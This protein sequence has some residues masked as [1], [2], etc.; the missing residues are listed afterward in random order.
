MERVD[1]RLPLSRLDGAQTY[2]VAWDGDDPV[3][4]AHI[5]WVGT[6]LGVPELQDVFV[7]PERRCRG[8]AAALNAAAERLAAA[9]GH[10]RI[11]LSVGIGNLDARQVYDRLGYRNAGLEPERIAGTIVIRGKPVEIEETLLHLVK[12]LPVDF[13]RS[14]SS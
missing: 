12:D 7:L 4:H 14:R 13:D 1:A 9:R 8:V 2:L 6:K 3:G 5:A 11:S 10:S